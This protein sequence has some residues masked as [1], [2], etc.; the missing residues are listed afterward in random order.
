MQRLLSNT[1]HTY[2]S[3]VAQYTG[4]SFNF[5][6]NIQKYGCGETVRSRY[7]VSSMLGFFM[8]CRCIICDFV[9]DEDIGLTVEGILPGTKFKDIPDDWYCP[10]CGI[11]KTYFEEL[12]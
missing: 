7:T 4:N 5:C 6:R 3:S 2:P 12:Q 10:L 11:D 1:T 8:K 9:Y